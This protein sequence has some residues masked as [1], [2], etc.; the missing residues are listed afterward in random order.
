MITMEELQFAIKQR[1]D[2]YNNNDFSLKNRVIATF[3]LLESCNQILSQDIASP[4][5]VPRQNVSAMDGYAINR[6]SKLAK[7][8]VIEIIGESQAGSAYTGKM[9]AGQGVRIFT[10]A[11]VPDS[12]DTVIMQENTNFSEIRD[13]LDKSQPYSI[14]LKQ[15]AQIDDNIRK[16]GEEIESGEAVLLAGKRLNPTD[17]SLLANLGISQV[18]VFEPLTVGI[19]ATGDELV[20]IGNELTSLAQ[21]YNSN[22]PTLKSLLSNLPIN[23]RDYGIIPDNLDQTMTAVNE[24]MHDCDVLISTAGVSV[25]DYDFLTTVIDTLGQINHYKVA[26]KPGKP[27]VF[28]ELNKGIDKPVLYFGLPGN[29]LST[30]VGALQ[31]VI[32]ALWQMSGALLVEQPIQL[33]LKAALINNIKKSVGRKDFQRGFLSQNEAGDYQVECFSGQQSHRI[34]QLSRANCFVVLDKDSGNVSANSM[35]TVQPF[36]WLYT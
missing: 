19:L 1:I 22:T 13:T 33:N 14:I 3:D 6:G 24:A 31:F 27:F 17:I 4:F 15:A 9:V 11:V 16:Q 34:K 10:G 21:I 12:C 30:V 25:G 28:G 20:A 5:D 7:D 35:V 18:K 2:D 8:S 26:M 36:P 32:P 23:I 29:P